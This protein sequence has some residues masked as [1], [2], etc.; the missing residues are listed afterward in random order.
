MRSRLFA[1]FIVLVLSVPGVLNLGLSAA[2]PTG[3]AVVQE[4]RGGAESGS[5]T[6]ALDPRSADVFSPTVGEM[7]LDVPELL[8]GQS[9]PATASEPGSRL[10]QMAVAVLLPPFLEGLQRPPALTVLIV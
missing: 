9:A 3:P 2:P 1:F 4:P 6:S 10:R 7:L 8:T 5:S